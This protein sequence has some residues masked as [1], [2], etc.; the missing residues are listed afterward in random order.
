MAESECVMHFSFVFDSVSVFLIKY[1][2]P[3]PQPLDFGFTSEEAG[4]G[5]I[6]GGEVGKAEADEGEVAIGIICTGVDFSSGNFPGI[7]IISLFDSSFDNFNST[8]LAVLLG[9]GFLLTLNPLLI[10]AFA[11]AKD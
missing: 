1:D 7:E 3:I 10:L 6:V 5:K 8:A 9:T 2:Q 11:I 4:V